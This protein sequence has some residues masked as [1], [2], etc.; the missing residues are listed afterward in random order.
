MSR[1]CSSR[2][3]YAIPCKDLLAP[4]PRSLKALSK[5]AGWP[6]SPYPGLEP[7]LWAAFLMH[8]HRGSLNPFGRVERCGPVP[9]TESRSQVCQ[10]ISAESSWKMFEVRTFPQ[11]R[12]IV[13]TVKL[14][15][16]R[17]ELLLFCAYIQEAHLGG[18]FG[19]L[20][21]QAVPMCDPSS[22]LA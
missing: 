11:D 15:T 16:G 14:Q 22:K 7:H 13:K 3:R 9:A 8:R 20:L 12:N 19:N 17:P 1:R 2:A 4:P 18:Y 6:I 10:N 21:Q 5:P